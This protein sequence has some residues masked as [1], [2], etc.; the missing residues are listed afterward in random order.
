MAGKE[1]HYRRPESPPFHSP[2]L[3]FRHQRIGGGVIP[4]KSD[5]KDYHSTQSNFPQDVPKQ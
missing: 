2:T 1:Y 5:D 3:V 4:S